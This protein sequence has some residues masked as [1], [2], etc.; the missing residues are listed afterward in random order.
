MWKELNSVT[1]FVLLHESSLFFCLLPLLILT[2]IVFTYLYVR[3]E[4]LPHDS[5][6]KQIR[7]P[8]LVSLIPLL[9]IWHYASAIFFALGGVN[10]LEYFLKIGLLLVC[11]IGVFAAGLW[12]KNIASPKRISLFIKALVIGFVSCVLFISFLMTIKEF[13]LRSDPAYRK[14]AERVQ[15]IARNRR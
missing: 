10:L 9:F 8:L 2:L 15:E 5:I 4:I 11:S 6:W 3:R 7:I 13:I 1:K 14:M 12:Y